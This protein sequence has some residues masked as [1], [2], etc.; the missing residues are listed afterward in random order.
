MAANAQALAISKTGALQS[1]LWAAAKASLWAFTFL[2]ALE[3]GAS[4]Y[5]SF[6]ITPLWTGAL[7]DSVRNWNVSTR[8][9]IVPGNF[10]G[11]ITPL[12]MLALLAVLIV[13]WLVPGRLRKLMAVVAVCGLAVDLS[14]VLFFIPILQKTIMNN[15]AGLS[16]PEITHLVRLWVNW[17]YVRLAVGC[18]GWVAAIEAL[19]VPRERH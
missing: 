13:M 18:I 7:P 8:Y 19:A 15:G 9:P 5:Q 17:D 11:T 2:T 6:V 12:G 1:I 14:T 16:G 10:W 4:I 3:I